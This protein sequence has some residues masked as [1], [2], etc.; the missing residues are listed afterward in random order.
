MTRAVRV[1]FP[2]QNAAEAGHGRE[3]CVRGRVLNSHVRCYC[4]LQELTHWFLTEFS[5]RE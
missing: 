4:L 5:V 2:E 1:T 3:S